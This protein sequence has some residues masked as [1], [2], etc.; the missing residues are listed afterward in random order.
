[1]QKK[2]TYDILSLNVRGIREQSKRR[3]IF[4]Y[5]KD[6]KSKFCFLQETYSDLND[7]NIWRNE[8][9]GEIFFSHGTR[10]S[11]GV[12]I[13]IHPSVRD[14]VEFI[15]TDKLGRIVLI[16]IVINSL[17]LSLCNIYAPNNQ[18]EQLEFLQE[19]N[20]C[21]IDKAELTTLIVGGDWNCTLSKSD[22]IGGKPW[23]ATNYRNLVLTTMDILDLID[24]QRVKHP[25]LR[26]YSYESKTL[27]VKSRIDFFLV[28]K[29]LEQYVKKCEI[30]SS[31]APD[32]KAI[33]ISLS[34][35]NP[36][37]R[38]PGLWKFNNSL[39]NDEEYVNKIRE[40]YAYTCVYYS[41]S[42]SKRLFWE[43]LKM[44]IRAATISFS[45]SKAKSTYRLFAGLIQLA[46]NYT[47]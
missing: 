23:R 39:L 44:E 36:T 22:K 35:S 20:N 21:L 34:W 4:S 28:A 31:V 47:S 6:Q 32:H 29:H 7:E 2:L 10:H 14:K 26:K 24:I 17:K 18:T 15:F 27:K 30:Y 12:C 43:M 33:Y 16:T 1:M 42:V 38:G 3:S 25:K 9:G 5:L 19:L 11:K 37:P 45:K 46:T 41:D 13:L 8:W 40:T